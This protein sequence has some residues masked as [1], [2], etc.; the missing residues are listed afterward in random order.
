MIWYKNGARAGHIEVVTAIAVD[1]NDPEKSTVST[2]SWG[3]SATV[4]FRDGK[5]SNKSDGRRYRRAG[6]ARSWLEREGDAELIYFC[7]K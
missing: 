5:F 1:P 7:K 4:T 3:R 2:L 6:E